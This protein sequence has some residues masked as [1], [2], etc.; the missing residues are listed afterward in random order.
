MVSAGGRIYASDINTII[1][2]TTG[3]PLVRLVQQAAQSIPDNAGT[4][5][6]FGAGS[7][8]IDTHGFHDTSTF[9]TRITP[10]IAGWYDFSGL[11]MT[12]AGTDYVSVQAYLRKNGSSIAPV[13][14]H[15]PNV[16]SSPRSASVQAR[17]YFNGSTDYMELIAEQDNTANTARNTSSNGTATSCTFECEFVRP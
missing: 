16:T 8:W 7:E 2:Y 3:K 10:T 11:Y 15:G 12:V 4:A 13:Q 5:L 1:G 17:D 14:R 6:T 9:T